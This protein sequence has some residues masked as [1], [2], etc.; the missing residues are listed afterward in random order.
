VGE[1]KPNPW[2]LYDMHGNV[3]EW[4]QDWYGDYPSGSVTDPQGVKSGSFRVRRGGSWG[5]FSDSCRSANRYGHSPDGR[6]D[7]LG[8][9]VLRSSIK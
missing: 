2:G 9:R 3:W 8:F 5:S 1:K 7:F 4:C 6:L